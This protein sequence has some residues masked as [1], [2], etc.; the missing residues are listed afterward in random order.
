VLERKPHR[1]AKP[2]AAALKVGAELYPVFR[3]HVPLEAPLTAAAVATISM[4]TG[5]GTRRI[6]QLAR[7]FRVSPIAESLASLPKGPK[8]GKKHAAPD[9][10]S[11]I[12]KEIEEIFLRKPP[13]S[14]RAAAKQIR[15][16]LIA[17]NGD[18][19]LDVADVPSTRTIE[20]MIGEISAPQLA[21][22]TMGSKR[23][24]AHEPHPGEYVSEGLLD[25]VQM[26]HS[27]AN[28]M[29][30]TSGHRVTLGR[31]WVTFLIDIWSRC[32]LG[33][34]V[35]FGDPS[36]ARCGRAVVNALLP[37]EPLLASLGLSTDYLMHGFFKRLHAD[38]AS[39]HR[40]EAF[41]SACHA[42]GIDPDVRVRGPSH[43]GGHIE[44]LIGTMSDKMLLLPGATGGDV[45]KRDGHDPEQDAAMTLDEFERWLIR[46]ICIY[47][48]SPHEGLG[49][50]APAQMWTDGVRGHGGLVPPGLDV[51]QLT[52]RFLPWRDRTVR[53]H[54]IFIDH[55]RYWH[56]SLAPRIGLQITVHVDDQTITTVYPEID[57]MLVAANVVGTI[58]DVTRAEWKA[59]AAALRKQ[60]RAYQQDGGQ[61][62]IA[63]LVHANRKEVLDAKMRTREQRQARK[64][65]EREGTSHGILPKTD[66]EKPK[67][68]WLPVD[69]LEEVE[70]LKPINP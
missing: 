53:A 46:E 40:S 34:Y 43:L 39:A 50:I 9:I 37:K 25:V 38:F 6:R 69:E 5:L 32:I 7:Q 51:E 13:P 56:A 19:K 49:K 22:T 60:G 54:G 58:P 45:T 64:R 24:T 17:D 62:E 1:T 65:L 29:L 2:S 36:I 33:F 12:D 11:I 4:E 44:R 23:R 52:R 15:S 28:V 63:R 66:N 26:D 55:C 48:H 27:P 59:A 47:H 20:R 57:G 31:P 18:Y 67:A 61:A 8:P 3:K 10:L 16:L 70:W 42:Y 14:V 41:R 30:V 21:R 68:N 35:S